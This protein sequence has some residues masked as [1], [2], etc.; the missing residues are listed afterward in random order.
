MPSSNIYIYT[1]FIRYIIQIYHKEGQKAFPVVSWPLSAPPA[2]R[3][4]SCW[5]ERHPSSSPPPKFQKAS[6]A[7]TNYISRVRTQYYNCRLSYSQRRSLENSIFS[8]CD[9]SNFEKIYEFEF[10]TRKQK[11]CLEWEI[12]FKRDIFWY[13]NWTKKCKVESFAATLSHLP[14]DLHPPWYIIIRVQ[15]NWSAKNEELRKI[16]FRRSRQQNVLKSPIHHPL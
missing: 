10:I 14:L 8:S 16:S 6:S 1:Y 2:K 4:S 5:N 11:S 12:G 13:A 9:I 7:P 3:I 15:K